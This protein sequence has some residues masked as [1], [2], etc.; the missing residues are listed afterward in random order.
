LDADT[1]K[2][3]S[4]F[5]TEAETEL[6]NNILPYWINYA[7]DKKNSGYYGR[8]SNDNT[9]DPAAAK[10]LVMHARFL[11]AYAAAF[12][13]YK[14]QPWFH[15][16]EQA[17]YFLRTCLKDPVY[18]GYFWQADNKGKPTDRR[19]FIYGQAFVIY[20]LSEYVRCGGREKAVGDAEELFDILEEKARDR[21]FG[22]YYEALQ[23]DW[24]F[25]D[26]GQTN[27]G[28][29]D[30]ACVKSM[31][32]NLHVL[33]AYTNLY[34]INKKAKINEALESLIKVTFDSIIDSESLHLKLFF[35]K[36]WKH[37][38]EINSYGHDIEASWLL[39]EALEVLGNNDLKQKYR[40][41]IIRM[42][43]VVISEGLD[44]NFG[45]NNEQEEGRTDTD[46]HWWPQA[47][48]MVGLF[49]AWQLTADIKYL[50]LALKCWEFTKQNIVSES[51]EWYW[52][53]KADGSLMKDE[54]GSIWKTPYH[55]SR[56]CMEIIER[57]GMIL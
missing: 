11:W 21:E 32:T 30:P 52:G 49:N 33:E 40:P 54:K 17:G 3:L 24:T 29:E 8:I 57:T 51:G 16:A 4:V 19:K 9:A 28:D 38:R 44:S 56:F 41:R 47:E 55:N 22:G 42:A 53:R 26:S 36:Q 7:I 25:P 10:G 45:L 13:L 37:F 48:M 31:N 23:E 50:D 46:K 5:K 34:R 20:G 39:W 12:R 14:H 18:G 15:A 6:K 2:K 1:E 35:D 43:D 27:L